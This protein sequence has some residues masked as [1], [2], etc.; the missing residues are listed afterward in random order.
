MAHYSPMRL[1]LGEKQLPGMYTTP[2]DPKSKTVVQT[3]FSYILQE[4]T[5]KELKIRPA[6]F[7]DK[8]PI[9]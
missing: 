3:W 7:L 1:G 2:K 4:L 6:L 5:V 8:V 9:C